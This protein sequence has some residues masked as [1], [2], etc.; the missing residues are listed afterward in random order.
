MSHTIYKYPF[1]IQDSFT[2]LLPVNSKVLRVAPQN[3]IPTMWVLH[4]SNTDVISARTFRIFGTGHF[5]ENIS[6][7][8]YI[9]TFDLNYGTWHV[10]EEV[11][12]GKT[13]IENLLKES[14]QTYS[15]PDHA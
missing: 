6:S 3:G 15:E 2:K 14:A 8:V 7:L 13:F 5:I 4:S 12:T 1:T 10:F 11:D 9:G